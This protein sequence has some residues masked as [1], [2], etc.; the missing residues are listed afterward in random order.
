MVAAIWRT[1]PVTPQAAR[2]QMRLTALR[3]SPGLSASL[4]PFDKWLWRRW[5]KLA[6][7]PFFRGTSVKRK[8]LKEQVRQVGQGVML[9]AR[10]APRHLETC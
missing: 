1:S 5:W 6:D 3:G 4:R 9:W 2:G 7:D 10:W 8:S